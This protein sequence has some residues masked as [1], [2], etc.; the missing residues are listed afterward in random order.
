MLFWNLYT[1][2]AT[3]EEQFAIARWFEA[4]GLD[5]EAAVAYQI[6]AESG[7]SLRGKAKIAL[8]HQYKKAKQWQQALRIWEECIDELPHVPEEVYI[9]TAKIHEHQS[10]DY[11]KALYYTLQAYERWKKKGALLRQRSKT[12]ETAYRKRIERLE[13]QIDRL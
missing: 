5:G 4:L 6:I 12:E 2:T 9:E 1:S 13:Q 8:G 3:H 7:H 10:K 11:E